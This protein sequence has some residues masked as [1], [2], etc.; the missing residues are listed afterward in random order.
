MSRAIG[1]R[2]GSTRLA[3]NKVKPKK[4]YRA[5]AVVAIQVLLSGLHVP[6]GYVQVKVVASL[7]SQFTKLYPQATL[8]NVISMVND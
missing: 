5:I 6:V 8:I 4:V 2:H 7:Y 1:E 3:C